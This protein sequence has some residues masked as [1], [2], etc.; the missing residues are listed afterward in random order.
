MEADNLHLLLSK[1]LDEP[2]EAGEQAALTAALAESADLRDLADDLAVLKQ[3]AAS[4]RPCAPPL[5]PMLTARLPRSRTGKAS[6]VV[7]RRHPMRLTLLPLAAAILWWLWPGTH[8][9]PAPAVPAADALA[10]ADAR[11][12]AADLRMSF[13]TAVGPMETLATRRLAGLS[14]QDASA[15]GRRLTGINHIIAYCERAADRSGT[16][17]EAY[18]GLADAYAAKVALLDVILNLDP[19]PRDGTPT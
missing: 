11:M 5:S 10:W 18:T 1:S 13:H 9:I 19:V 6:S 17:R 8:P 16:P 12:Q 2:L 7:R 3:L 14:P 4:P 15:L